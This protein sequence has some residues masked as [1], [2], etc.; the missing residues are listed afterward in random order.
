M[1]IKVIDSPKHMM[2][3]LIFLISVYFIS[4]ITLSDYIVAVCFIGVCCIL[5]FSA[6][7]VI[8]YKQKEF[9]NL[10]VVASSFVVINVIGLVVMRITIVGEIIRLTE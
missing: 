9:I 3:V 8:S 7:N 2:I 1:N 10:L 5:L 6:R 4:L